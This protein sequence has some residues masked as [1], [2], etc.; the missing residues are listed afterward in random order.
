MKNNL[1]S[2]F[3]SVCWFV[4]L[5]VLCAQIAPAQ[6]TAFTYTTLSP[7][8]AVTSTPYAVRSANAAAA[9]TAT[10]ATQLGGLPANGFIQNT[11]A[12]QAS[13]NFNISGDGMIGGNLTVN[14]TLSLNT[15]NANTQYNLGGQRVL[16]VTGAGFYRNNC[17]ECK[18]TLEVTIGETT[19]E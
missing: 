12:L 19:E 2:Q 17:G 16:S 7:R 1:P 15:V 11:T 10:N 4:V 13:S 5:I 9:D 8:Q 6:G 18:Q 3:I 14:G